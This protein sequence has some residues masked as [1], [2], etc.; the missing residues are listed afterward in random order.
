MAIGVEEV[1]GLAIPAGDVELFLVIHQRHR[2]RIELQAERGQMVGVLAIE[3]V[4]PGE[5][6]ASLSEIG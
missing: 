4:V 6:G 5:A 1:L 2:M 3:Q